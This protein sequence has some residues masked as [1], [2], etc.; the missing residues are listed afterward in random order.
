MSVK[1]DSQELESPLLLEPA[2]NFVDHYN[3]S[4]QV[5]ESLVQADKDGCTKV[6]LTNTSGYTCQLDKGEWLVL[7]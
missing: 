3:G 7:A 4:L 6:L 2:Y 1:V 5:G